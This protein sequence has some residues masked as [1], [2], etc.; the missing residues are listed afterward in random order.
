LYYQVKTSNLGIVKAYME[1]MVIND[2]KIN[3]NGHGR[4]FLR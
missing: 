3:C 1:W 2:D 4:Y